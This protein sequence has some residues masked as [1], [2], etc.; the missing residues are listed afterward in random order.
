MTE[1]RFP[2]AQHPLYWGES[3]GPRT[4]ESKSSGASLG[5][6]VH[7]FIPDLSRGYSSLSWERPAVF[8]GLL[9]LWM[10]M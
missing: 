6:S 7:A 8:L 9:S 5:S 10:V 4:P 2:V 3:S 1:C